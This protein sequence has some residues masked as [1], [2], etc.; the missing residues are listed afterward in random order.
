MSYLLRTIRESHPHLEENSVKTYATSVRRIEKMLGKVF[1]IHDLDEY[2]TSLKNDTL[3]SNLLS[4][5][6][7]VYGRDRYRKIRDKYTILANDKLDAQHKSKSETINWT[8]VKRLRS[9]IKRITSDLK[10]HNV[11]TK[12]KISR[13]EHRLLTAW[14]IFTIHIEFPWRADLPSVRLV[15]SRSETNERDNFYILSTGTFKFSSFKTS[16]SWRRRKLLPLEF[17]MDR[18]LR[19]KIFKYVRCSPE[20]DFLISNYDG[21]RM[22]KSSFSNVMTGTSKRYLNLRIGVNMIRHIFISELEKKQPTLRQRREAARKSM[23][24]SIETQLRYV[25]FEKKSEEN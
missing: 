24:L 18:K 23:Q 22:T 6:I 16:K 9:M 15:R 3:A 25:R 8:S 17:K 7:A 13:N 21:S 2:L 20:S 11:F 10:I 12:A 1:T 19:S 14:L 4:G 5:L